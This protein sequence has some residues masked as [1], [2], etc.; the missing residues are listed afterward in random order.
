MARF[1]A[2][3]V[4]SSV[5]ASERDL[6][7]KQ[8]PGIIIEQPHHHPPTC[9]NG[10]RDENSLER[11]CDLVEVIVRAKDRATNPSPWR[12]RRAIRSPNHEK[13]NEW[14]GTEEKRGIIVVVIIVDPFVESS[15]VCNFK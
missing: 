10:D 14:H 7:L 8:T 3:H 5:G 15:R 1:S 2:R 4:S 11:E 6:H 13:N 12:R 9:Q